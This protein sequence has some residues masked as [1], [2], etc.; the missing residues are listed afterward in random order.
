MGQ[1]NGRSGWRSLLPGPRFLITPAPSRLAV[2][3]ATVGDLHDLDQ[4]GGVVHLVE[5]AVVALPQPVAL[6]A[7]ELLGAG[8]PRVVAQRLDPSEDAP[9]VG[10]GTPRMSFA[11]EDLTRSS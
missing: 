10:R 3:V 11:T 9:Q 8:R 1:P 4:R 7:R 5:H 6:L 2:D